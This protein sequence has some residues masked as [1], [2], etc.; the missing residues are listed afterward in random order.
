MRAL[1]KKLVVKTASPYT[2][3]ASMDALFAEVGLSALNDQ[4]AVQLA[5][6]EGKGRARRSLRWRRATVHLQK[7]TLHP[8]AHHANVDGQGRDT[9]SRRS[10]DRRD[11]YAVFA[12]L[13]H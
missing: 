5:A 11:V 12:G 13:F 4:K 2:H 8:T 9:A 7:P 1:E 10:H 3:V 6:I